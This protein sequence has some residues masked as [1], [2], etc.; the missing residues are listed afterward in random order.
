[1]PDILIHAHVYYPELWDELADCIGN[2]DESFDLYVTTVGADAALKQKI[3]NRFANA[4]ILACENKGFDIAPFFKVLDAV[5][6]DAY[7]YLIKIHTKRDVPYAALFPNGYDL[8]DDGWRESLLL[9]FKTRENWQKTAAWLA[10]DETGMVADGKVIVNRLRSRDTGAC[11]GA[12]RLV[13]QFGLTYKGDCFIAGTMF[14]AKADL[15]KCLQNRSES[16]DFKDSVREGD[17]L[18]YVCE[19][20]LGMIVQAQGKK[21]QALNDDMTK[22]RLHWLIS[23]V[24]RFF[25]LKKK[26]EKKTIV[27]IC[28]I[29]V[30]IKRSGKSS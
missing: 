13:E 6:L 9:P 4:K 3:T 12:K 30:F 17:A 18:P 11:A 15:F 20:L 23:A 2:I 19:R 10:S 7:R 8:S 24:L 21:I 27:K 16:L 26:S 29:P 1:M 14:A 22:V 5:D 25:F 28:K